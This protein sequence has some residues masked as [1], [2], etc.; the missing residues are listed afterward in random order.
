MTMNGMK[1]SD[2]ALDF[3]YENLVERYIAPS[4]IDKQ[5]D[6]VIMTRTSLKNSEYPYVIFGVFCLDNLPNFGG[7]SLRHTCD[8]DG[9]RIFESYDTK[10]IQD[11]FPRL[12][13][14]LHPNWLSKIDIPEYK[15]WIF[16]E[17]N[18]NRI[19]LIDTNATLNAKK[20]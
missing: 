3:P 1:L 14:K 9:I 18:E 17:I 12:F 19:V 7:V 10:H 16:T 5:K 11:V 15:F 2:D 13:M 4:G 6:I 8:I 20:Q